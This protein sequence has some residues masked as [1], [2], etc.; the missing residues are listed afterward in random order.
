MRFSAGDL[1]PFAVDLNQKEYLK[2]SISVD[3]EPEEDGRW[4]AEVKE[5]P[6]VLAYGNTRQ[7]AVERAQ[8]LCLRVIADRIEN[9]KSVPEM[10]TVFAV[11]PF[12]LPAG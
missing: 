7:E 4:L 1:I 9:E 11:A 8:V 5:F 10:N 2:M 12:I 3:T 6:G